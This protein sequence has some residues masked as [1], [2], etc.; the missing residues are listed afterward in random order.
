M[1][2]ERDN[3]RMDEQ[4]VDLLTPKHAP[5]CNVLFKVPETTKRISLWRYVRTIGVAAVVMMGVFFGVRIL[6]PGEARAAQVIDRAMAGM[7]EVR[8]CRMQMTYSMPGKSDSAG[9]VTYTIL[10][11]EEGDFSREDLWESSVHPYTT[12]FLYT[13]DSMKMWSNGELEIAMLRMNQQPDFN[14]WITLD[15]LMGNFEENKRNLS[16]VHETDTEITLRNG[17]H[18]YKYGY[19]YEGVFSKV[20]GLLKSFSVHIIDEKDGFTTDFRCDHIDYNIPLTEEEITK[21]PE[22]KIE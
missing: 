18:A 12:T 2:K 21:A 15:V 4:V 13:P 22:A 20:D 10:R 1:K 9:K 5:Q 8:S 3:E 11:T 17:K 7:K 14:N 16:I 6:M 19:T